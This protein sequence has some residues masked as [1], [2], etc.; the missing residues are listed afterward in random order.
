VR[1]R[2]CGGGKK[3]EETAKKVSNLMLIFYHMAM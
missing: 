2:G 1:E 3:F